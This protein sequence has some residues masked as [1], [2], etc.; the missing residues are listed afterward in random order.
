MISS[1]ENITWNGWTHLIWWTQCKQFQS[2]TTHHCNVHVKV[3]DGPGAEQCEMLFDPFGDTGE[4]LLAASPRTEQN[5]ASGAPALK[6]TNS[7]FEK[8][9]TKQI[10][11]KE[12]CKCW[13]PWQ[14]RLRSSRIGLV[15][16]T[17]SLTK[18]NSGIN[19]FTRN[20]HSGDSIIS[21]P[22]A[23]SDSKSEDSFSTTHPW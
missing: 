19:V 6:Q 8:Q 15:Y 18:M 12:N 4:A 16:A 1:R 10:K 17:C 11:T 3:S 22:I 7:Y 21:L 9:K 5:A 13:R 23:H 14:I 2:K 20:L